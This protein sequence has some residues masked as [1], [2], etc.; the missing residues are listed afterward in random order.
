MERRHRE[1][2]AQA[3]CGAWP[4]GK[5]TAKWA[6]TGT[7]RRLMDYTLDNVAYAIAANEAVA[8]AK[9]WDEGWNA[10]KGCLRLTNPYRPEPAKGDSK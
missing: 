7:T 1:L 5:A 2:A 6:Q 10:A 8:A 4:T 9:A 3:M